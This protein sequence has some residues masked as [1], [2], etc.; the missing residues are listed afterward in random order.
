MTNC[1]KDFQPVIT[2]IHDPS[3][4]T[5]ESIYPKNNLQELVLSKTIVE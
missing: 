4:F 2:T 3:C 1:G 5:N